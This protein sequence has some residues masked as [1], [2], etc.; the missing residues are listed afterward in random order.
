[1]KTALVAAV[2]AATVVALPAAASP[3]AGAV[4]TGLTSDGGTVTVTVSPDGT[5][6]T[7]FEIDGAMGNT[8]QFNGGFHIPDWPGAPISA[9]RF[10]AKEGT[11][12]S[13]SGEFAGPQSASGTFRFIRPGSG[14]IKPCDTGVATW[15][16]K[17]NAKPHVGGGP[18]GNPGGTGAGTST[19]GTRIA[20]R[21]LSTARVGGHLSSPSGA[22]Q[23]RRMVILW[24]GSHKIASTR[25]NA[26]GAFW[27]ARTKKVRGRA[28]RASSPARA[29]TAGV[30][31][32]GSSTFIRG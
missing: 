16:A 26:N 3:V 14:S 4:Y 20:L 25:S 19:F 30:C 28:V 7:G 12:I 31:A 29:M 27:F 15:S 24:R 21:K 13:F 2:V 1:M 9:N 6:V 18:G 8:C 5:L 10:E 11:L 17:T 23:A 22:C 32:A